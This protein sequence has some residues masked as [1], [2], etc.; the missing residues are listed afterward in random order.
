[1]YKIFFLNIFIVYRFHFN[2]RFTSFKIYNNKIKKV[3]F[4]FNKNIKI[5]LNMN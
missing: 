5:S 2:N 4:T 3:N 1:M